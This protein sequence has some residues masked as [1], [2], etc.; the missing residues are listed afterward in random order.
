MILKETVKIEAHLLERV[1]KL[2]KDKNKRIKYSNA[3]QFVSVAV[4]RLLEQE[5]K[6]E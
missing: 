4:L 5:E 1:N 2:V 3:K 6:N